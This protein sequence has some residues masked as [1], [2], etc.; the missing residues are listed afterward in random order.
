MYSISYSPQTTSTSVKR[1]RS[2]SDEYESTESF[3]RKRI[4]TEERVL[5]NAIG[6]I[7]VA[8]V[9]LE[10]SEKPTVSIL[11]CIA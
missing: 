5:E 6:R 10:G 2:D 9:G 3:L 11:I 8:S 7:D 4:A 1:K